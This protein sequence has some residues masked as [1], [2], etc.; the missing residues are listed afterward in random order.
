M[1]MPSPRRVARRSVAVLV[2]M[3]M[4]K[5]EAAR[6]VQVVCDEVIAV[7]WRRDPELDVTWLA[8]IAAEAGAVRLQVSLIADAAELAAAYD[9]AFPVVSGLLHRVIADRAQRSHER[10]GA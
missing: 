10:P 9:A 2:G 3:G 1:T 7:I 5:A 4:A 8:E 6:M